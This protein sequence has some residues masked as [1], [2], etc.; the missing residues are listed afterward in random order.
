MYRFWLILIA[1]FSLGSMTTSFA[2]V[3]SVTGNRAFVKN[4]III[5]LKNK[6]SQTNFAAFNNAQGVHTVKAFNK[7]NGIQTLQLPT[8]MTVEQALQL[9]KNNPNV[10][11]AEPDYILHTMLTPNDTQ[12]LQLWGMNNTGQTGG[13]ADADINAVEA[14]DIHT[15][16]A[17]TIVAVIDTGIDVTHPDL[18]ANLWVNPGEIAGNGID[19]DANGYIDDVHGI[20]AIT[21]T[22]NLMDDAGHGTHVSGTITG[23]GNNATGVVGVSWNTKVIGCKFLNSTGSGSTSDAVECLNYLVNLKTRSN[24]PVDILLSNNS[25]GSGGGSQALYDAIVASQNAGML[26][27]AAA[28]NS[29]TNNDTT[30]DYPSNYDLPSIISVAATDHD[31][32]IPY[33]SNY[34]KNSVE[35]AAPGVNIVSTVPTGACSSCDPSGYASLSGTSMAAPHVAGLAAL[36][37]SQ[38]PS[39][40]WHNIKNLIMSSGT[41]IPDLET[42]I[43]TGKR[44][45]AADSDGTGALT[46]SDQIIQQR[47]SPTGPSISTSAGQAITLSVQHINCALPNGGV[48]VTESATG[49]TINLLD[50]GTG[51][52]QVAGD[53]LY[54]A[55]FTPSVNTS[56]TFPGND[57]VTVTVLTNYNPATQPTYNYRNISGTALNVGGLNLPA[58]TSPFPI[59]FAN[60]SSGYSTLYVSASGAV[61]FQNDSFL[62][63]LNTSLP[64]GF[65]SLVAPMW[66]DLY[67]SLIG[68]VYWEVQG[69][70]PNREL[71]IEWR[72]VV[73][74][75]AISTA[76]YGTFQL[77]FFEGSSDILMNYADLDFGSPS[78]NYGVSATVGVQVNNNLAQ[79]FS[80]N[81]LS[82]SGVNALLFQTTP[83]PLVANAGP[84]QII[85]PTANVTLDGAASSFSTSGYSW[86]QVAGT[87]VSLTDANTA[88]PTFTAP[89]ASGILT[90]E[91]TTT[92][93]DGQ[94]D[95][96]TVNINVN[97]PPTANAGADQTVQ[98]ASNVSLAGSGVDTDGTITSYAWTQTAGINVS[99]SGANTAALS[100]TT[101]VT[102][103]VLTFELT[104]TDN[105]GVTATDTVS[106]NVNVPPVANA[107]NDQTVNFNDSVSLDGTN[108]TDSDGSITDYSWVQISGTNVGLSNATSETASFTAPN[109][110]GVLQFQLTVTDDTGVTD[111]DVVDITINAPPVAEA[112]AAQS[113]NTG[114]SLSLDGAAST[115]SDGSITSYSWLQTAGAAVVLNNA[116]T[117]TPGFTAPASVGTLTFQLTVTDNDGATSTDIVMVTVNAQTASSSSGGSGCTVGNNGKFDPTFPILLLLSGIY[118]YRRRLT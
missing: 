103:G 43:I 68:G 53:G 96:D 31:D 63:H 105:L 93:D 90:F 78:A 102:S 16:S 104:V 84:D 46:C 113:V 94:S 5:K 69:S 108:S 97:S 101:P 52:D 24:N 66:D 80:A 36:I 1:F 76:N 116:N 58:I 77:V 18:I 8:N 56:L 85:Q 110:A 51:A 106:I 60:N 65:S 75:S 99:L 54:T 40:T 62:G 20:N 35:V 2:A 92:S 98:P 22:G 114:G 47:L 48:S 71:I 118:L 115:D 86:L 89:S 57:V 87:T 3:D 37:K 7:L 41:S 70:A 10:E 13:T 34:G 23:T 33:F 67:P 17:T 88:T 49:S 42:D 28:G 83:A 29:G 14:W 15:G 19:D 39:Y 95:T 45:R 44:I 72:D 117:A 74:N 61:S 26:F 91:L 109:T 11:Y 55:S 100:F 21:R 81:T 27:I 38:Y 112:G 59:H 32:V 107:G 64:Y 4:Q 111:T 30:P 9:Y 6:S 12:F 73:H 82:L 50:D 25:W 79:Q